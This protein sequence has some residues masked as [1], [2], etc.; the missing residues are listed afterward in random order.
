LLREDDKASAHGMSGIV[1]P[2]G[3]DLGD[4][5][6]AV[7][8]SVLTHMVAPSWDDELL[9]RRFPIR[10]PRTW[11]QASKGR[12]AADYDRSIK[13]FNFLQT[14]TAASLFPGR[15]EGMLYGPHTRDGATALKVKWWDPATGRRVTVS[16]PRGDAGSVP[17]GNSH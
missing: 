1:P 8:Q 15:G 7:W 12:P 10:C 17:T 6:R 14:V 9:R 5:C 13:P 4:F 11:K 16:R 3:A 2:D